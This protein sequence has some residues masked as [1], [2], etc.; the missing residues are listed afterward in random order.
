MTWQRV[1]MKCHLF[2][3]KP[4]AFWAR[5]YMQLKAGVRWNTTSKVKKGR[6]VFSQF[7]DAKWNYFDRFS[8]P[9]LKSPEFLI[10]DLKT[11]SFTHDLTN[12]TIHSALRLIRHLL[13]PCQN[14]NLGIFLGSYFEITP[15]FRLSSIL[16][17]LALTTLPPELKTQQYG[18]HAFVSTLTSLWL[19]TGSQGK[20]K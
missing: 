18:A 20:K 14:S 16:M 7:V 11:R 12:Y 2:T 4:S 1:A 13:P 6:Q 3:G 17:Y 8:S 15:F 9:T 19:D 10:S 5:R